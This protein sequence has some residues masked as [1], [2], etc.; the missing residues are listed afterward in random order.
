MLVY[1]SHKFITKKIKYEKYSLQCGECTQRIDFYIG[2]SL[3]LACLVPR[4]FCVLG[5]RVE[6]YRDEDMST[7]S[8]RA[9]RRGFD[10]QHDIFAV[11][12]ML[13]DMCIS[14]RGGDFFY[15]FLFETPY[16]LLWASND[17]VTTESRDAVVFGELRVLPRDSECVQN[18]GR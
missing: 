2:D 12:F 6:L 8:I 16:G 17:G 4:E 7:R 18:A 13:A 9:A 14:N 15:A 1:N 5:A 3:T 10:T 11:T